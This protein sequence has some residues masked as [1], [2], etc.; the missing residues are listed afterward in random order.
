MAVFFYGNILPN[1][2]FVISIVVLHNIVHC[3]TLDGAGGGN[4]A[5]RIA[6][7]QAWAGECSQGSHPLIPPV[8]FP[9]LLS[10]KKALAYCLANTYFLIMVPEVGIEPTCS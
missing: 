10:I 7:S 5:G 2:L 1:S 8:R 3:I 4:P 9:P 6:P